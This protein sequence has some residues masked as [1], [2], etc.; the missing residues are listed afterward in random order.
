MRVT[1]SGSSRGSEKGVLSL[2][3]GPGGTPG[4][5]RVTARPPRPG[6]NSMGGYYCLQC[7]SPVKQALTSWVNTGEAGW[8][9]IVCPQADR[10]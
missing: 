3:T 5:F 7:I 10:R 8:Q 1:Q 9:L 2:A 6:K 4:G